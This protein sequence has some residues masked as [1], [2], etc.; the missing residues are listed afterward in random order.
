VPTNLSVNVGTSSTSVRGTSTAAD[1]TLTNDS[2]SALIYLGLGVPA[3]VGSGVCLFPGGDSWTTTTT[4][5][6]NAIASGNGTATLTG[7]G[8]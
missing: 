8:P 6:I 1:L 7:C 5:A 2:E 4:L 3:V